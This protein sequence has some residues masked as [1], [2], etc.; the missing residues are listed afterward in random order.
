[1]YELDSVPELYDLNAPSVYDHTVE[2]RPE[3]LYGVSKVYGEG[4]G[5]CYQDRHGLRVFCLRIGAVRA[6]EDPVVPEVLA[7]S[8]ALLDLQTEEQRRV[9]MQ[10]VWLSR[11]DCTHLIAC[12]LDADD[13]RWAV[14][15]GIS[16]NPRQFGDPSHAR[17]MLGYA[18]QDRAPV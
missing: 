9:G 7:S 10:A 12:C 2:V 18:P 1:M 5:R 11:R 15:Y 3:S 14:V 16:D 8:P 4:L 13:V 6:A 17:E